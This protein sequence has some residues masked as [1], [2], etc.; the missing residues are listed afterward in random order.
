VT[1]TKPHCSIFSS[2]NLAVPSYLTRTTFFHFVTEALRLQ[3][4]SKLSNMLQR[5]DNSS[6]C[7]V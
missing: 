2:T 4:S 6:A 7:N 1:S 5:V 3:C